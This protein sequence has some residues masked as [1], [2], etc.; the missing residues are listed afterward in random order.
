MAERDMIEKRVVDT[1]GV[2]LGVVSKLEGDYIEVSEG[3]F[4]ELL[5]RNDYI[6]KEIENEVVLKDNVHNLLVGLEVLDSKDEKIGKIHEEV[7]AGDVLDTL[8]IETK[9]DVLL[10]IT[11][12]EIYRID[13]KIKLDIDVEEVKY[14]QETHTLRDHVRHYLKKIRK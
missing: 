10:F 13:D 6:G 12:E 2:E 9:G 3:L 1:D 11:L 14:R 8:L 5:L 4:D 7:T